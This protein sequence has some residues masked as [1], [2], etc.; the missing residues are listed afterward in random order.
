MDFHG[1]LPLERFGD[2][3][4]TLAR[5]GRKTPISDGL[6]FGDADISRIAQFTEWTDQCLAELS[7]QHPISADIFHVRLW[8]DFPNAFASG[9]YNGGYV[10]CF[11]EALFPALLYASH[12][13]LMTPAVQ[14]LLGIDQA[15]LPVVEK[16]ALHNAFVPPVPDAA[17][18]HDAAELMSL[19]AQRF[20]VRHEFQHLKAGHLDW[21]RKGANGHLLMEAVGERPK[22]DD[23]FRRTLHA[24]EMDADAFALV[25]CLHDATLMLETS[26]ADDNS[27]VGYLTR[28]DEALV[29]LVLLSV[30]M[31]FR[32]MDNGL[33]QRFDNPFVRSHPNGAN[34][35]ALLSL[36]GGEYLKAS[37]RPAMRQIDW[38]RL[39]GDV[40]W[41]CELG[42]NY[43]AGIKADIDR[44]RPTVGYVDLLLSRWAKIRPAL[45]LVK[46]TG[47]LAE[48]CRAPE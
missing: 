15:G 4:T 27:L 40:L 29:K 20:I 19:I 38:P 32:V 45:N 37:H 26:E 1:N 14:Q 18:F 44:L 2:L 35:G 22:V 8:A 10:I 43:L 39:C 42:L 9:L 24:L 31:F 47:Q 16:G 6:R 5:G 48:P 41:C 12:H 11:Y 34:R 30:F 21:L 46:L 17:D 33:L 23:D 13:I 36:S 7:R 28:Y 3:E 25:H